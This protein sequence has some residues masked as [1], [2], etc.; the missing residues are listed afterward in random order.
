MPNAGNQ[1]KG[2]LDT[3]KE[4]LEDLRNRVDD[5]LAP[6]PKLVPVPVPV[7]NPPRR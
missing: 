6:K 5:V 1:N 3:L 4:V 2:L 7:K